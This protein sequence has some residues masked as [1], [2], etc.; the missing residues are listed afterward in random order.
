MRLCA[1]LLGLLMLWIPGPDL[2]SSDIASTRSR[3]VDE[4][5]M[6]FPGQWT[7]QLDAECNGGSYIYAPSAG[8]GDKVTPDDVG[9]WDTESG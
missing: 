1:Q 8:S 9:S 6:N 4:S 3:E 5:N 2:S 7:L